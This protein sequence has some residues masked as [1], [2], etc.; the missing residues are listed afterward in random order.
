MTTLSWNLDVRAPIDEVWAVLSDTDA[1]NRRAGLGFRFHRS[2]GELRG[3]V[4]VAGIRSTWRERPFEVVVPRSFRSRRVYDGGPVAEAVTTC[5]LDEHER[6]TRVRYEVVLTPSAGVAGYAVPA[7]ARLQIRPTLDRTLRALEDVLAG[8]APHDPPPPLTDAARR[9]LDEALVDCPP[10]AAAV[11][12]E[13]LTHSPRALQNRLRPRQLAA[14][15]DLPLDEVLETCLRA[16]DR[17]ALELSFALL[18]PRCREPQAEAEALSLEPRTTHCEACG[19][20]WTGGVADQ[21]EALFRPS[22]AVRPDPV[23]VDCAGSPARAPHLLARLEVKAGGEVEV[24]LR[25]RPGSYRV[26]SGDDVCL[27]EVVPGA[28]ASALVLAGRDH[29]RPRQLTLAPGRVT[30]RVRSVADRPRELSVSERWRPP[31]VLPVTSFLAMPPVRSRVSS[32]RLGPG[33]S[34]VV[35]DGWVVAVVGDAA[36]IDDLGTIVHKQPRVWRRSS[37]TLLAVPRDAGGALDLVEDAVRW[38]RPVSVGIAHGP[39]TYLWHVDGR[40]TVGG[41]AVDRALDVALHL[42]VPRVAVDPAAAASEL[43][44][45]AVE[46]RADRVKAT[47]EGQ[48]VFGSMLDFASPSRLRPSAAPAAEPTHMPWDAGPPETIGKYVVLRELGRGGM[49]VVFEC[50]D[51]ATGR[52]LAAKVL[53]RPTAP[54]QERLVQRFFNEAWYASR[55]RHPNVVEFL[56]FGLEEEAPWIAMECLIGRTLHA[57]LRAKGLM[58][59]ARVAEMLRAVCDALQ[60]VHALGLVHR[61]LKP[62]NVFVVDDPKV[63]GGVKLLD[64]GLVRRVGTHRTEGVAGTPDYV[65]PEQLVGDALGPQ[66][67]VYAVGVLAYRMLTGRL[68]VSGTVPER[69]LSRVDLDPATLPGLEELGALGGAVRAALAPDPAERPAD[70][71]AMR[72]LLDRAFQ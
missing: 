47:A 15:A 58:P 44:R 52:R 51:T 70:A 20:S 5:E 35:E 10:R 14:A 49:G 28:P 31:F 4:R 54:G 63:P 6:G 62:G 53:Q 11:L 27:V 66:A 65:S 42:G 16:T 30:L 18:C 37:D 45:A 8:R 12:K 60:A 56:D 50:F 25:L 39:V 40:S 34:P 24:E 13:R 9:L 33:L 67:D 57:E 55:I 48:L 59:H 29:L 43:F 38:A 26:Q 72:A 36:M 17:G 22:P 69:V 23:V 7:L 19:I 61:D 41:E 68:P 64:F 32:L 1:F 3:E 71:A 21:V 2:G 46:A